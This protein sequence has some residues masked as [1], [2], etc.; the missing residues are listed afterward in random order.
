M[1]KMENVIRFTLCY[2][3]T[4]HKINCRLHTLSESLQDGGLPS[5]FELQKK[6]EKPLSFH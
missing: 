4:E 5:N 6:N 3:Q 2:K 1:A